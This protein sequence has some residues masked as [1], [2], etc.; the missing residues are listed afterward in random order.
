MS[1]RPQRL[2]P[3][4]DGQAPPRTPQSSFATVVE[5]T[6][7]RRHEV[8]R[9]LERWN[10]MGFPIMLFIGTRVALLGFSKFSLMLVPTLNWEFGSR[11]YLKQYPSLDGLCRWDCWHFATIASQGYTEARWTN[12]FPLYPFLSRFVSAVT[13]TDINLALL[14]VSNLASLGTFL[15]IYRVFL[16]LA[17]VDVARISL[18]LFAAYPFAFF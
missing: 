5:A 9:L 10:W 1:S 6:R 12:F 18:M 2:A 13:R 7:S 11:E 15:L 16:L 17:E 14:I 8:Q 3:P 4:E